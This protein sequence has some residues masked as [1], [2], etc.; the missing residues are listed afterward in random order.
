MSSFKAKALSI[1]S[2]FLLPM[3]LL[4]GCASVEI[5][6]EK[7]T[8]LTSICGLRKV[9]IC[10]QLAGGDERCYCAPDR[11]LDDLFEREDDW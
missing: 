8:N 7:T 2:L 5:L 1:L 6:H 9:A 4:A 3:V 10:D 11:A